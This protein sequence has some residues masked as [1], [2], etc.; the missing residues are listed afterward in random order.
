[1]GY[2]GISCAGCLE[3]VNRAQS[4]IIC[5]LKYSFLNVGILRVTVICF[6]VDVIVWAM[7]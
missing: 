4:G 5:L 6:K 2:L 7:D 1:M 3:G